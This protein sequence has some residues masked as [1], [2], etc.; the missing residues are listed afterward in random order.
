MGMNVEQQNK[1]VEQ[2]PI[3][4]C[5][6]LADL[7]EKYGLERGLFDGLTGEFSDVKLSGLHAAQTERAI[8]LHERQAVAL[9]G[10]EKHL[11]RIADA[12]T[13]GKTLS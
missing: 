13:D 2:K 7:T 9:E 3:P 12:M 8:E 11:A 5:L 10:I 1:K 6:S 4:A